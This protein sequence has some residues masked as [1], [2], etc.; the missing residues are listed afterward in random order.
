[1]TAADSSSPVSPRS[2]TWAPSVGLSI[3]V[4]G[5]I[6]ATALFV[7]DLVAR[8]TP[9]PVVAV[10]VVFETPSDGA[11]GAADTP[12][13]A[14]PKA[15]PVEMGAEQPT[16]RSA[17]QSPPVPPLVEGAPEPLAIDPVSVAN[18]SSPPVE[19]LPAEPP[20]IVAP[21]KTADVIE[22]GAKAIEANAPDPA[23]RPPAAATD[24][25]L[26]VMTAAAPT[27]QSTMDL[28]ID[29]PLEPEP[30]PN[31][32]PDHKAVPDQLP[33][34]DTRDGGSPSWIEA[35]ITDQSPVD[36]VAVSPRDNEVRKP[37]ELTF[38][39]APSARI[40]IDVIDRRPVELMAKSVSQESN[41]DNT[42]AEPS[43]T[44]R[45]PPTERPRRQAVPAPRS[46][47]RRPPPKPRPRPTIARKVSIAEKTAPPVPKPE[48]SKT[49]P[50]ATLAISPVAAIPR[51]AGLTGIGAKQPSAGDEAKSLGPAARTGNR[52]P[53]YPERA[54]R[55][56]W[57][58]RVVLRVRV[59]ITGRALSV[60]VKKSSGY[61]LLD[62]VAEEAV[63]KW[64]FS[65][66]RLAG[67]PV[68]GS[69]DVPIFFRLK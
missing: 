11:T 35:G 63:R 24:E 57:E 33:R 34:P 40:A 9:L 56:G 31:P 12:G 43:E 47:P 4:H 60:E 3:V 6:V 26:P 29:R 53:K 25:A 28:A 21:H 39:T 50:A 66:G 1:V 48:V 46:K 8:P 55:R 36:L 23:A 7:A 61:R 14:E 18:T 64:R 68:V 10:D 38:D 17:D 15:V 54:R 51:L 30:P 62:R 58:G 13:G 32:A 27:D 41:R 67:V 45:S 69:V 52:P 5:A 19:I 59:A 2:S 16:A 22:P 65:S 44:P 20:P 42:E 37:P 49:A